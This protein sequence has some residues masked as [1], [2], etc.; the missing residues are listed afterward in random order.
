MSLAIGND[1]LIK[2]TERISQEIDLVFDEMR[3]FVQS[4][5]YFVDIFNTNSNLNLDEFKEKDQEQLNLMIVQLFK[6]Q[7]EID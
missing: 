6:Q 4:Y 7:E 5:Q 2:D 3:E 1:K